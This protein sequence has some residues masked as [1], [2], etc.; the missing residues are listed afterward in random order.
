MKKI[1]SFLLLLTA[2]S[3]WTC[4]KENIQTQKPAASLQKKTSPPA[5]NKYSVSVRFKAK[6][7]ESGTTWLYKDHGSFNVTL[8]G[9]TGGTVSNI[10]NSNSNVTFVKNNSTCTSQLVAAN[11]GNVE[12]ASVGHVAAFGGQVYVQFDSVKTKTP[13]FANTCGGQTTHDG[14]GEGPGAPIYVQ[15]TDNGQKQVYTSK[16]YTI[17]VTPQ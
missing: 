17:T 10:K 2:I 14:G 16:P 12:I 9:G 1:F 13:E 15:F 11:K 5:G 3:F 7:L 8:D 6:V 4:T